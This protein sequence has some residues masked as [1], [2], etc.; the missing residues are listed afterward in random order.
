M[1]D[2]GTCP[3]LGSHNPGS[4]ITFLDNVKPATQ[5][6]ILDEVYVGREGGSGTIV[7]LYV[8]TFYLVSGATYKCRDSQYLG[9]ISADEWHVVSLE[10][11]IGDLIGVYYTS[12]GAFIGVTVGGAF[13]W[14]SGNN[15]SPGAEATY[16]AAGGTYRTMCL[17]GNFAPASTSTS[18]TTTSTSTT[19]TLSPTG[20]LAFG[21]QNPVGE[22]P[23]SWQTYSDGEGDIPQVEGDADWGKIV[24]SGVEQGR[25]RVYDFGNTD[26]RNYTLE[27]DK[28]GAGSGSGTVQIRGSAVSFAQD[29]ALPGWED[30]VGTIEQDWQYVQAR[31]LGPAG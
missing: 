31:L 18:T 22:L 3:G 2:I 29:D 14:A 25:S 30:Y 21:E 7:G 20:G 5:A 10:A 13:L 6:G 27:V 11:Q 16:T 1:A 9:N 26:T 12:S 23:I 19:T 8:G 24:L 28:Y 17:M 4:A 15:V